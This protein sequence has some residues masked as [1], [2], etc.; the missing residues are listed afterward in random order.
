MVPALGTPDLV[1]HAAGCHS[2]ERWTARA[3]WKKTD[4]TSMIGTHSGRRPATE[5]RASNAGSTLMQVTEAG[6]GP[7]SN[8][9]SIPSTTAVCEGARSGVERDRVEIR[10]DELGA[11]RGREQPLGGIMDE[12]HL[13]VQ[14]ARG[15]T[16]SS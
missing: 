13:L 2:F 5:N 16:W 1:P 4:F 6:K 7:A 8:S 12:H 11:C 10:L 3:H 14:Q 15:R 9:D